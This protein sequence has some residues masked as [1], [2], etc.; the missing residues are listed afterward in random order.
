MAKI[1]RSIRSSLESI[2]LR[3]KNT[4]EPSPLS[5]SR[6]PAAEA[7]QAANYSA[8]Q[9]APHAPER[10]ADIPKTAANAL[11]DVPALHTFKGDIANTM[12]ERQISLAAMAQAEAER[13]HTA[14]GSQERPH[15]WLRRNIGR[16]IA[17]SLGL[18]LVAGG[19]GILAVTYLRI[20]PVVPAP[21]AAAPIIFVDQRKEITVQPG[22]TR[23]TLM[24]SLDATAKTETLPLGLV[25]ALTLTAASTTPGASRP[26]T[27]R[28]F[29]FILAPQAPD[30]LVR[31]LQPEFLLGLHAQG[32][33]HPFLIF[34]TDEFEVAFA[35]MLEWESTMQNDLSPLFPKPPEAP[36]PGSVTASGSAQTIPSTPRILNTPFVDA[37]LSNHDARVIRL[38]A[39]AGNAQGELALLWSFA[40]RDTLVITTNQGT[41][42]EIIS[43]LRVASTITVPGN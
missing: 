5:A 32:G 15:A 37:I 13:A 35:G 11:P 22:E 12:Q 31:V 7:L 28:A 16:I 14:G 25:E 3:R 27:A 30:R 29:F 18:L 42:A 33:N 26:L 24:R 4:G 39:Q 41:L 2:L 10:L 38:P 1:T 34:K 23:N 43:R 19:L 40:D 17:L 8:P 6:A 9:P 21:G 20:A 36:A